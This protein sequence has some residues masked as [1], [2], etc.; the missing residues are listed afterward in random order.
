M[1]G[2]FGQNI[3]VKTKEIRNYLTMEECP[4]RVA[5]VLRWRGKGEHDTLRRLR[6]FPMV[7][8]QK[9]ERVRS[10]SAEGSRGKIM[11]EGKEFGLHAEAIES[12]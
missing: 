7:E 6:L 9:D 10:G 4:D 1:S 5:D 2:C 11:K 12:R 8:P 3:S